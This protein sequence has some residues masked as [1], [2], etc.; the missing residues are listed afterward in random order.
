MIIGVDADGV[1]TDMT[2]FNLEYGER[3]FKR[4]PK[5]PDGYNVCEMFEVSEKDEFKFGL[6]YF[7]TYCTKWPPRMNAVKAIKK[8]E[9]DGH[10]LYEITARKFATDN[11]L[12]GWYSRKMFR[13]W[14]KKHKFCFKDIYFCA[15]KTAPDEKLK[16]CHRLSVD[17]MIDD[18]P[19]VA[20]KIAES[21]IKVLMFD[22][23]YNHGIQHKN[24]VRVFSWKQIYK[25]INNLKENTKQ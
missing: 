11:N 20:L 19:D 12:L 15:E 5:K 6:R 21:G 10:E 16:E 18:K 25:E 14:I 17:V 9:H 3:Y 4:K 24:I 22:A 8:L 7:I 23:P 1:L 2:A 13:G